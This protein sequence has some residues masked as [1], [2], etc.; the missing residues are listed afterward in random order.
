MKDFIV[1]EQIRAP[2]VKLILSNG[3]M[4]GSFSKLAAIQL[5]RSED[6]DLV[7]VSMDN[8]PVCRIADYG[9]MKYKASKS[10][11]KTH[12]PEQKETWLHIN[13]QQHD[14][15]IKTKKIVE[16]LEAKHR[17][18]VVVKLQGR[19]RHSPVQKQLARDL[20][21]KL[22]ASNVAVATANKVSEGEKD[23]SIILSPI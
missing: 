18:R 16:W 1:N 6:M 15:D 14:L 22:A 17:V 7:Q 8:P 4:K 20:L 11:K 12:A 3:E 5:A 23:V 13:T 2:I 19:E 9:K 10:D 21:Q